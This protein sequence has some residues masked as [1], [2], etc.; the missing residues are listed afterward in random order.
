MRSIEPDSVP[1]RLIALI[2]EE[3]ER[4]ERSA[5]LREAPGYK[6]GIL[7]FGHPVDAAARAK[8]PLRFPIFYHGR[9]GQDGGALYYF[10]AKR[11][12]PVV[13]NEKPGYSAYEPFTV[14]QGWVLSRD[15]SY[16][17]SQPHITLTCCSGMNVGGVEPFAILVFKGRHFV[18]AE[19]GG[20]E[21]REKTIFEIGSSGIEPVLEDLY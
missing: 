10:Q 8:E 9:I 3:F 4:R 2:R 6:E 20:W 16:D 5:A 13:P 11:V 12:Y 21:Y 18:I 1:A 17:F 19:T 15:G 14:F 7:A